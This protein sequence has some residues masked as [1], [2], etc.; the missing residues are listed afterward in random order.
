[1]KRIIAVS[2]FLFAMHAAVSAATLDVAPGDIVDMDNGTVYTGSQSVIPGSTTDVKSTKNWNFSHS[3]GFSSAV[4]DVLLSGETS[5]NARGLG[6]IRN[7]V[8]LWKDRDTKEVVSKIRIT[9][10][11]GKVINHGLN[12]IALLDDHDYKLRVRGFA[13]KNGGDYSFI[14][15][16]D[17]TA[18]PIP[19]A[20]MLLAPAL[21]GLAV[22]GRR[23]RDKLA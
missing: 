23:K 10:D 9:N 1:M 3:Y 11:R 8:F 18:V 20:L 7:L 12:L 5:L 22:L 6:T 19:G 16:P 17:V 2:A 14:V 13:R 4:A 21:L 15:R